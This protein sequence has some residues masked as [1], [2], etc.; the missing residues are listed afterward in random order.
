[1][2]KKLQIL[3]TLLAITLISGVV[4]KLSTSRQTPDH[5]TSAAASATNKPG[6][7]A[8]IAPHTRPT[9]T[10]PEGA[11]TRSAALRRATK[12]A[13]QEGA[14]AA[15]Q[16]LAPTTPNN[17]PDHD[18]D[19]TP[20][21]RA[22]MA[23]DKLIDALSDEPDDGAPPLPTPT[24]ELMQQLRAAFYN[25]DPEDRVDNMHHTLNLLPDDQFASLYAILFDKNIDPEILDDIFSDALNR[26]DEIKIPLM[27]ELMKD[28]EHPCHED[29]V[30]ILEATGELDDDDDDEGDE[31]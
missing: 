14:A 12:E 9:I 29:A 18:P 7:T 16:P 2:K 17:D 31:I 4:W 11:P 3:I 21:E 8:T 22:V 6:S 20:Q 25:M 15:R 10:L 24:Y 27:K 30:R 13:T 28:E 5:N 1:M 23:W 19:A 26:S